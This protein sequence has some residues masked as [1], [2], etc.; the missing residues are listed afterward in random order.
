MSKKKK[1]Y[2]N[3]LID[4]WV[5][6]HVIGFFLITYFLLQLGIDVY[7][8]L[9]GMIFVC[10]IFEPFED[11]YL[12]RGIFKELIGSRNPNDAVDILMGI[13]G[14]LLAVVCHLG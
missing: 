10:I 12:D 7:Y 11:R 9:F 6:Y 1:R 3:K 5:I 13:F 2:H 8:V 4:H 14:I